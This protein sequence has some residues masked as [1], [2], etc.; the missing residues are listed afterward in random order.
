MKLVHISD[1]HLGYLGQGI[2][3]MVAD[4]YQPGM[5]VRQWEA[6]LMSGLNHTIDVIVESIQPNL[7]IHSGDLFDGPRPTAHILNFAMGQFKRLVEAGIPVVLVEGN[8]SSPRDRSQGHILKLL[9]H[10]PNIQVIS[11]DTQQIQVGKVLIH[12]LPH[13][14]LATGDKSLPDSFGPIPKGSVFRV[15]VAHAVADGQ[16]FFKSGRYA[17]DFAVKEYCTNYDYTALGH[18]HRFSQVPGTQNAFYAG[19][20]AMVNWSDF[21]P[22]HNFSINWL[23]I[24][25]N[26]CI[27]QRKMLPTR[28]MRAYGLNDAQGLSS[29]EVYDY[30]I[31]QAAEILPAN[32]YCQVIV[33]GL[34]PLVRRE[35]KMREVEEIFKESACLSISLSAREQRWEAVHSGLLEGGD[36]ITRFS[37]LVKQID[38]DTSFKNEVQLLGQGLL[39]KA[40]QLVGADDLEVN[41][42]DEQDNIN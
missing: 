38:G 3:R 13:R 16:A 39:E 33:E 32:A 14:A 42:S 40:L 15:L 29:H 36:P 22:G 25:T 1:T 4:P 31:A 11:E 17:P 27:I 5:Q 34:D 18:C 20:S 30:L 10:L 6:D 21:R 28:S 41:P 23:D 9:A 7:V 24:D 35:L 19:A 2:Q 12:G 26:P 8:R 37:L